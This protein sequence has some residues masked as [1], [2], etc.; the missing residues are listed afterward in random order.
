MDR[1]AE[2]LLAP[3]DDLGVE[4]LADAGHEAQRGSRSCAL[5]ISAPAA[6]SMRSAVGAVYQTLTRSVFED[7][8]PALGVEV[9]LVDDARHP[10]D[11][12]RD[13][14]VGG[15]GH[16]PG[17]GGA[18]EHV[19]GVEVEGEPAGG[20]VRDDRLVHVDRTL[21]RARGAAR[22][23]EQRHV[24]GIRR[25]DLVVGDPPRSRAA[26]RSTV[27]SGG[28][29]GSCSVPASKHVAQLGEALAHPGHLAAVEGR[30][31]D[32]HPAGAELEALADGLGAEGGEQRAEHRAGA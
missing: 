15:S 14:P 23:V 17:V 7:P 27:P 26:S 25:L 9:A 21:G 18:P 16:P 30:R 11:Q 22:E 10:V 5:A 2:R 31:G 6:M 13:D 8:V 29:R 3:D 12:G 32:E 4:G 1:Q 20:V 24:F 28:P 19:V